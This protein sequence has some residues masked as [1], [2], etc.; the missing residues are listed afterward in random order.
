MT[1][2]INTTKQAAVFL[3]EYEG[4]K[5]R[6]IDVA[7]SRNGRLMFPSEILKK[8]LCLNELAKRWEKMKA[9]PT[10]HNEYD[11]SKKQWC[12]SLEFEDY[13]FDNGGWHESIQDAALMTTAR[14]FKEIEK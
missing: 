13:T 10:F 1:Q 7:W 4:W 5:K 6:D 2:E 11:G 3:A 14:A 8:F 9:V 12:C